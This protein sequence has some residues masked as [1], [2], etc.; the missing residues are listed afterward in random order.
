M[1]LK[2]MNVIEEFKL[3]RYQYDIIS[4]CNPI[5]PLHYILPIPY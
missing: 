1:I 2:A 3:N 5:F 4:S